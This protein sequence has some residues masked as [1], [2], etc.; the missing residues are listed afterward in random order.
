MKDMM[1]LAGEYSEAR[2]EIHELDAKLKELKAEQRKREEKLYDLMEVTELTSISSK[3]KTFFLRTDQYASVDATNTEACFSWL[4]E[5][6]Y[7][8]II[9]LGVNAR[10]LGSAV[11]DIMEQ[12]G[13]EPGEHD[14]INVRTI[15]RV[16]IR[17]K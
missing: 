11:K 17:K 10:T 8:H 1:V 9:K 2:N 7:D 12:T 6:D 14:G 13:E 4:R 5:H 16:G 3:N 15:D